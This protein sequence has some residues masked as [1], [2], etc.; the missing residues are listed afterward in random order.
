VVYE[1]VQPRFRKRVY[2]RK[3]VVCENGHMT[4]APAPERVGEKTRYDASFVA[5]VVTSQRIVRPHDATF[6]NR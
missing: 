2:Q 4:T 1:Y 6:S 3:T 5:H